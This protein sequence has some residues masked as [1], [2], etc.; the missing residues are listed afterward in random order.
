M[1]KKVILI[2]GAAGFIGSHLVEQ[3]IFLGEYTLVATSRCL[4]KIKHLERKGVK[5][6]E[7]DIAKKES[8]K[9]FLTQNIDIIIHCA[10]CVK[11]NDRQLLDE[12]NTG[13]TENV[14]RLGIELKVE[15]FVYLSSVAVVSGNKEIPLSENLPYKATN[16]YGQSKL[17]AEKRVIEYR[18]KG[19]P[20]VVIRPAMVYGEGEPHA[21]S[22][23]IKLLRW[24]LL[25][26]LGSKE[27]KLHLV[28][29][30]NVVDL[31]I[32][33]L[34]TDSMSQGTFFIADSQVLTV[35]QV[36][37]SIARALGFKPPL[38]FSDFWVNLLIRLP[39]LGGKF[40]FFLKDRVYSLERLTS[41]GFLPA[42]QAQK[43]L[44]E[45]CFWYRKELEKG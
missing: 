42:Y 34:K 2:T 3:L 26:V 28:Y 19:L 38:C 24:R 41:L 33:S 27:V 13:G 44:I 29:V 20:A 23:L 45:T 9:K 12:V 14:C 4:K 1:N 32:F 22:L 18:S 39:F 11:S 35:R 10:A 8:L 17:E 21:F 43:S 15:K 30:K 7:A 36:L 16:P 5:V 31:I 37:D 40:K 25:P 6:F